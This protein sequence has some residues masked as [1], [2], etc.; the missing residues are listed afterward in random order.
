MDVRHSRN[1]RL[2]K[3]QL[4]AFGEQLVADLLA[5][6]SSVIIER[7]WRIREGEIDL[8][9]L[10]PEG[11]FHFVEVKTRSSTSFGD[12]LESIG[13]KKAHRLQK[14]A[15]AWLATHGALGRDFQIDCAGVLLDS[16][17]QPEVDYRSN[18]L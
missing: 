5:T 10:D 1:L 7:N 6:K 18:I 13:P 14:L 9:A 12:P 8:I 15:L 11:T 2:T 17:G 4:G 3:Q 16:H